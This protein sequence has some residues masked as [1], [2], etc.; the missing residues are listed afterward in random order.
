MSK[1][2]LQVVKA[3]PV[4][5]AMQRGMTKGQMINAIT[6][7]PVVFQNGYKKSNEIHVSPE[8]ARAM[9]KRD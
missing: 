9:T 4:R 3:M 1:S 6:M 2:N 5:H 8:K 7:G